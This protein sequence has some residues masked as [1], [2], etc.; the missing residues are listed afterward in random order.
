MTQPDNTTRA[1]E[2]ADEWIGII[3]S[4]DPELLV[5][6]VNPTKFPGDGKPA[7]FNFEDA[8]HRARAC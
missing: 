4:T 8:A 3:L 7:E 2:L 5:S 6:K 1:H